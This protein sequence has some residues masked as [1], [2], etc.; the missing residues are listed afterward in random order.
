MAL[1][2]TH[3]ARAAILRIERIGCR[4]GRRVVGRDD[5]LQ[6]AAVGEGGADRSTAFA[7]WKGLEAVARL[8]FRARGFGARVVGTDAGFGWWHWA[9][10]S[11]QD[12]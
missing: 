8:L 4:S 3:A 5:V 6:I 9:S 1:E 10:V 7:G 12:L 11:N 2:A